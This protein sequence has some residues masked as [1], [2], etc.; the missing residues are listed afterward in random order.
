MD[1]NV[2]FDP[3]SLE[4]PGFD[5]LDEKDS[6]SHHLAVHTPD[7]PIRDLDR[8]QV[9]LIGI[10]VDKHSPEGSSAHAPDL[11]RNKLYQLRR[12]PSRLKVIDLGNIKNGGTVRDA[13]FALREVLSDLRERGITAIILGGTQDLGA[14]ALMALEKE[15][16]LHHIL[17]IDPLLD[18]TA[19]EEAANEGPRSYL[20]MLLKPDMEQRFSLSNIGHQAYFVT[21]AQLKVLDASMRES[22]RLGEARAHLHLTEP[23]IRDS[24]FITIDMSAIRQGDA[25]GSLIPSPNGFSGEE[26]CQM[27]RYAG[28]SQT[29]YCLGFFNMLPAND[30]QDQTAHLVAQAIWYFLDGRIN[31]VDE[32]PAASSEHMKQFI[33][34]LNQAEEDLIFYKS[35][36]SQRWWME[37]PVK[38]PRTGYNFFLACSYEDYQQAAK[39]EIPDRWWRFLH[40]IGTESDQTAL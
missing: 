39:H 35:T 11:I 6:F 38:N 31:Q 32:D 13:Y 10:P 28:L 34:T 27:T 29:L 25:P 4:R 3:V 5:I 14:G 15:A 12:I 23:L 24:S 36:V 40:K 33:V 8:Y 17:S 22:I 26:L 19:C 30:I 37:L 1:L 9:A 2:Y 20:D 21:E 7:R 18:F 16:G